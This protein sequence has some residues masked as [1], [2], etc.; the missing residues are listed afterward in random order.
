MPY[1]HACRNGGELMRMW[2]S[3]AP[4]ARNSSVSLRDCRA[5]HDRIVHQDHPSPL[6]HLPHRVQIDQHAFFPRL[7]VGLMN[8]RPM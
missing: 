7:P 3:L 1:G 8:V 2:T 4:A 5:P 6:H